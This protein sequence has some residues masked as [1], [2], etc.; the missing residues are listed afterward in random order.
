MSKNVVW[1][2]NA[3]GFVGNPKIVSFNVNTVIDTKK[4]NGRNLL[5]TELPIEG[6]FILIIEKSNGDG[7]K[8]KGLF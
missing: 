2:T 8:F 7:S 6:T 5:P 3:I 1:Q 4:S